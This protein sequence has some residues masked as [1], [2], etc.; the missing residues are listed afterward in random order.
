MGRRHEGTWVGDMRGHGE[1]R[2]ATRR[3]HGA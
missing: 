3:E 2:W 1:G